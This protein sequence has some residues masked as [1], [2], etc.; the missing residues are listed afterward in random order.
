MVSWPPGDRPI[1]VQWQGTWEADAGLLDSSLGELRYDNRKTVDPGNL[2][3][4]PPAK[5]DPYA[6]VIKLTRR[7]K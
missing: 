2:T 5:R 3:I 4:T 1:R 7:A 6:T